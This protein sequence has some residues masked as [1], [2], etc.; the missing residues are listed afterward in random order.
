MPNYPTPYIDPVALAWANEEATRI[1]HDDVRAEVNQLRAQREA[2]EWRDAA[3]KAN[4]LPSALA[5]RGVI[6][7]SNP[8]DDGIDEALEADIAD[9]I[10]KD[11]D[12]PAWMAR[13]LPSAKARAGR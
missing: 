4:S 3:S 2:D 1:E 13:Q 8:D 10:A 6:Q 5:G 11:E 7:L 9:A 12:Y